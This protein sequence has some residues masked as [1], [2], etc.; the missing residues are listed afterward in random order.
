[1]R[2]LACLA[3]FACT[4]ACTVDDYTLFVQ[5]DTT[6][7]LTF[8]DVVTDPPPPHREATRVLAAGLE[9][10]IDLPD[11]NPLFWD[12]VSKLGCIIQ[13][14]VDQDDKFTDVL[15]RVYQYQVEPGQEGTAPGLQPT[16]IDEVYYSVDPDEDLLA[17]RVK[18]GDVAANMPIE[19]KQ[20]A[21]P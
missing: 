1:M 20:T 18:A 12:P 4:T 5:N 6:V 2:P 11:F 9:A 19:I 10:Q 16:L 15:V 3:L 13:I 14:G 21:L 7:P 8:M 17:L